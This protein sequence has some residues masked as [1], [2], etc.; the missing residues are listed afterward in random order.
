MDLG[1]TSELKYLNTCYDREGSRIMV[2]YG[3]K[4]VGKTALLRQ[5]VQD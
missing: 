3:H 1:R 5:F 4:N 2:V